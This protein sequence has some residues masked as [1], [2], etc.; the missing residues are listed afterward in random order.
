MQKNVLF[1]SKDLFVYLL[2]FFIISII[3]YLMSVCV[4]SVEVV[5][6]IV[7]LLKQEEMDCFLNIVPLDW[8][9]MV[10]QILI[11][12]ESLVIQIF[13]FWNC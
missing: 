10:D 6:T 9:T 5:N 11:L 3:F 1:K 12:L 13:L 2:A 7:H 4:Y 8:A